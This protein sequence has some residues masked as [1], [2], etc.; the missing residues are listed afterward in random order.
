MFIPLT[1]KELQIIKKYVKDNKIKPIDRNIQIDSIKA[2][3][4]FYDNIN[5]KCNIYEVRPFVCRD[6]LCC[7]KDWKIR[8]DKY[9]KRAK[10]NSSINE[11]QLALTFDDAIYQD[12]SY[13]IRY[14]VEI[15]RDKNGVD[16]NK[17]LLVLRKMNRLDL[18][19]YMQVEDEDGNI[20]EGRNLKCN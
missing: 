6:F 12:Y 1:E 2:Q 19:N 9:E 8:R 13:I 7:R 14:I 3:C 11:N 10:Y 17:L 18:L 5:K 15:C 16:S 4:C 20:I